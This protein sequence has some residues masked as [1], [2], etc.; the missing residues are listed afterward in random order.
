MVTFP[1]MMPT[2]AVV[3]PVERNQAPPRDSRRGPPPARERRAIG[4]PRSD[5][6]AP[7]D[8]HVRVWRRS[9]ERARPLNVVPGLRLSIGRWH[10]GPIDVRICPRLELPN[11]SPDRFPVHRRL[12]RHLHTIVR[13]APWVILVWRRRHCP[14]L[15]CVSEQEHCRGDGNKGVRFQLVAHW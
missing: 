6:G 9:A 15:T 7:I 14:R 1:F 8:R 2:M 13:I 4:V 5:V 10:L 12:L 3:I 11:Q